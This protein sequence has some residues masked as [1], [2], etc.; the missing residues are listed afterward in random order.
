MYIIVYNYFQIQK[1]HGGMSF[2]ICLIIFFLNVLCAKKFADCHGWQAK[3]NIVVHNFDRFDG[4][5]AYELWYNLNW[6]I[7]IV[8]GSKKILLYFMGFDV[9]IF[10]SADNLILILQ[11]LCNISFK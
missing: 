2:F 6:L 3:K 5:W 10:S 8:D 11:V 7:V 4:I 1:S 9:M